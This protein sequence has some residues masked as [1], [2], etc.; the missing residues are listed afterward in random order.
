MVWFDFRSFYKIFIKYT[1]FDLTVVRFSDDDILALLRENA[2]MSNVDIAKHLNVTE[3]AVRKRI[4]NLEEKGIISRYTV[5]VNHRKMGYSVR[6]LVGIDTKPENYVDAL[7]MVKKM[8]DVISIFTSS[9]DH[10]IMIEAWFK[11]SDH[12]SRFV[13][14]IESI[15]GVVKICPAILHERIK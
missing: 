9:G 12:L 7:D 6:A 2:R 3:T 8:D 11:D 14:N 10:M 15:D 1:C 4:K 5:E 13:K